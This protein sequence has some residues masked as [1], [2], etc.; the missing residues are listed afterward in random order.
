M[1][2]DRSMIEVLFAPAE[3]TA[4]KQRDLRATQC[5]VF[6]I[7]R[8]TSSMVTALASGATAVIPVAEISEALTLREQQPELLLAGERDGVRIQSHL[9]GGLLFDLGNSP[10]EFTPALVQGRRIAMTT[11]NGT[12]ALRACAHARRVL[13][14]ALLNLRATAELLLREAPGQL[15]LVCSGTHDQAAYED[16]LG[17]GALC[18]LLWPHYGSGTVA[19][20]AVM[21][22]RLY[23]LAREDLAAGLAESRNGRRLLAVPALRDD[24]PFCAQRDV[25]QIVAGMGEDGSVMLLPAK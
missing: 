15:L 24:V 6:D 25:L 5:V 14:G 20:S 13:I 11:T 8:A 9:T 19:D 17:A 16:V 23:H 3:F 22:R 2:R 4:L 1:T 12:R 10:R 7:L 21:A 18:D